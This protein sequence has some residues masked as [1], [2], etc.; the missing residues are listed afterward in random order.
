MEAQCGRRIFAVMIYRLNLI[1]LPEYQYAVIV[2][3]EN[4]SAT[5]AKFRVVCAVATTEGIKVWAS[6]MHQRRTA[7]IRRTC[8]TWERLRYDQT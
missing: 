7:R 2:G 5:D 4:I 1:Q 6:H 8:L 3:T